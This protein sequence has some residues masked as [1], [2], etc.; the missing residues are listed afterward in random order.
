[1]FLLEKHR[2]LPAYVPGDHEEG[3]GLVRLNTNESP[4]PPSPGVAKA[5]AGEVSKLGYYNDPDCAA[6]RAALAGLY[7]V[8]PEQVIA[9]NGSDELLYFAF[10]AFA[11]ENHP[12]A[13]PD[14]TYGYY[15]LFAAAH[16]IPLEKV[17]LKADFTI[18]YRDYLGIGKTIVFP[19]PNAPTGYAMPVWQMAEIAKSNPENVLIVDEAY[20]DFGAETCLPLIGEYPNVLI[21]RTFSKSRSMAGAR[22]GYGFACESLIAELETMRNAINLYSVNRMTQAAGIAAVEENDYYMANCQRIIETREYTTKMLREQGFE[23]LGS[24]ANFVFAR[25]KA[26]NAKTL[27]VQLRE[28]GILVRHWDKDRIRDYLR[29]T[30][31]AMQEMQALECAIE[32]IFG[33]A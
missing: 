9:T 8:K 28:R 33:R 18:D 16:G 7:G 32:M 21:V 31:G 6:L 5:I 29:I 19:N 17:P 26:M 27:A 4:Y 22:L 10:L 30:I 23:V 20:V 12:I 25:P 15:D 2:G 14:I 3:G 13:L 24:K 11:D 1:M